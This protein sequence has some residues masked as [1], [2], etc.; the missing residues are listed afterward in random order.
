MPHE[1]EAIITR[2]K[3]IIID[4][5]QLDIEPR[6]IEDEELLLGGQ[7][8]LDSVST[9]ELTQSLEEEFN[10]EVEDEE[11]T[12]ELFESAKALAEYVQRKINNAR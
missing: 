8:G 11:L 1:L 10:I 12:P 3:E 2:V 4:S 5:L 9:L 7:L 6:D